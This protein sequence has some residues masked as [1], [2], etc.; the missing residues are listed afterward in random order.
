MGDKSLLG[1]GGIADVNDLN[2]RLQKIKSNY[3]TRQNSVQVLGRSQES[4][5]YLKKPITESRNVESIA[6]A[7]EEE[8][9]ARD[10]EDTFKFNQD[11]I[12]SSHVS[13]GSDD[14]FDVQRKESPDSPK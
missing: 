5:I 12:K 6:E 11:D 2:Q 8:P 3:M 1:A 7:E 10:R 4:S 14:S 9:I 13:S